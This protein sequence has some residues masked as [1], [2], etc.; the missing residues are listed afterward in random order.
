[1]ISLIYFAISSIVAI[2]IES[3]GCDITPAT[4][5]SQPLNQTMVP[6]TQ[7][8]RLLGFVAMMDEPLHHLKIR[9][10]PP[11]SLETK[12]K[13]F[14]T[15]TIREPYALGSGKRIGYNLPKSF[16]AKHKDKYDKLYVIAHG[17]QEAVAQYNRLA[18]EL[19]TY[20]GHGCE[21]PAVI[22]V[23]WTTGARTG[24]VAT[25]S[26]E[27]D[28][29]VYGSAVANSIVVGREVALLTYF[30]TLLQ[31]VSRD[32]VH[33][34]G[35]GLGAQVMHVA[36][37]WYTHLE[38]AVQDG[39]GGPRN[40][41][42]VGRITGLDPSARDFQGYGTA[43]KLPYLN[44]QDADFV[45]II[46][47][48]AVQNG[49]NDAD[50]D[51]HRLGMS[52]LAGNA[53]FY[54]NGGQEQPFCR[55][56]P[57]CSYERALHYFVI[58]MT[59]DTAIYKLLL[60]QA[61]NSHEDYLFLKNPPAVTR[62]PFFKSLFTKNVNFKPPTV[63]AQRYLGIE[64]IHDRILENDNQLHG[65]YSDLALNFD[66]VPVEIEPTPAVK[67]QLTDTLKPNILSRESYDFSKFPSHATSKIISLHPDEIPG[68]GRFLAP[69]GDEGRVHFGLDAYVKQFPW[70]VCLV[71]TE[72]R[73]DGK[74]EVA[75]GCTGSL[76]RNDFI[77]TAAH[78][79]KKY[80]I[81]TYGYPWLRK[82]YHPVYLMFGT[83]C[84]RPIFMNKVPAKQDVTVFIHRDYRLETPPFENTDIALVKLVDPVPASMLPENGQFTDSTI[85]NTVCWR[86]ATTF[87]YKDT[88]QELY[89][90]GYGW[91]EDTIPITS[92]SLRWSIMRLLKE[93]RGQ[94]PLVVE[95]A[96]AER[97]AQRNTCGGDSGGPLTQVIEATGGPAQTFAPVSPYTAT[98]VGTVIG[99]PRPCGRPG[100]TTHFTKVG[101]TRV[102][103]WIDTILANNTGPV[104]EGL[105]AAPVDYD[106]D[107]FLQ[108]IGSS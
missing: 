67:L 73:G 104:E 20:T 9:P 4:N 31:V 86:T 74:T 71:L 92:E 3:I 102:N 29:A 72:H 69:P 77:V 25:P 8:H 51:N 91:N 7:H 46:H 1:M 5:A 99:G 95:V 12:F 6:L 43:A 78:C 19:L 107:T 52:I 101:H 82:D 96:N 66:M 18:Y 103:S 33:Y 42:K 23:D 98:V 21:K 62:R 28:R 58:S 59:N 49:G 83:D 79:F 108:G 93:Y 16:L 15:T 64:A 55:G 38:E 2:L 17:F 44:E 47:T 14:D 27:K 80:A 11:D 53:D 54:P 13:L 30:L 75:Q 56:V 10:D 39:L 36:G 24:S 68:C 61:T 34:I 106:I 50:V 97:Q 48:S 76:I 89:F 35:S 100:K 32:Q 45:D 65:F 85:L 87:D 88:C 70:N 63:Y 41:I 105:E 40:T 94:H 60:S 26:P 22:M 81:N 90:A 84:R 37:Q 57:R